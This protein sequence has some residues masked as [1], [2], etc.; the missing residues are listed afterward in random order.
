MVTVTRYMASD[1]TMFETAAECTA[2]ENRFDGMSDMVVLYDDNFNVITDQEG[3]CADAV[4]MVVNDASAYPW[5]QYIYSNSGTVDPPQTVGTWMI[6][7]NAF[8]DVDER[9]SYYQFI[10]NSIH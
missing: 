2:Y 4:Y 10:K 1:G 3:R 9:I 5:L 6:E 7:D 8:V